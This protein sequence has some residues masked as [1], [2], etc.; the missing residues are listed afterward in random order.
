MGIMEN[1]VWWETLDDP[2]VLQ[3]LIWSQSF[4]WIPFKASTDEVDKRLIR[5]VP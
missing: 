2:L 1:D 3:T 4:V 5:H